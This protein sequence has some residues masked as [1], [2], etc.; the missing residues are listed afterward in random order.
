MAPES[1]T[2]SLL[3]TGYI[4]SSATVSGCVASLIARTDQGLDFLYPPC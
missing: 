4:Q 3:L 1:Y 2:L